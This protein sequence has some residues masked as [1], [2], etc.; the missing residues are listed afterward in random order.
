MTMRMGPK[1]QVVVPKKIR[2]RLGLE[3]G[4]ELQVEER[5]GAVRISKPVTVDDL[6]GALPAGDLD[7]LD[8]LRDERARDR[9][10]EDERRPA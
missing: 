5:D 8:V 6:L 4:D 9:I 3:P 10:R 2:E 7:P 1:G